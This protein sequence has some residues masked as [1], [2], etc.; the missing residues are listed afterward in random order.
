LSPPVL[1]LRPE[2]GGKVAQDRVGGV[3]GKDVHVV[4]RPGDADLDQVAQQPFSGS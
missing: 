4:H 3:E 2:T 1:A